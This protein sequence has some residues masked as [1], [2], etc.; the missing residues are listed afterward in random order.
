MRFETILAHLGIALLV[1]T[2]L[3]KMTDLDHYI[4]TPFSFDG[5]KPLLT[6]KPWSLYVTHSDRFLRLDSLPR[7]DA[8]QD[9]SSV[10]VNSIFIIPLTESKLVHAVVVL[11]SGVRVYLRLLN[12]SDELARHVPYSPTDLIL[13]TTI[14]EIVFIRPPPPAAAIHH[15]RHDT[16]SGQPNITSPNPAF[17]N[18]STVTMSGNYLPCSM[19]IPEDHM[20]ISTAYYSHG[21]LILAKEKELTGGFSQADELIGIGQDLIT[22]E[23]PV[24]GT[25]TLKF[26]LC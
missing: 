19:V 17:N 6:I 11:Q 7:L 24:L 3:G 18:P 5:L 12:Y 1:I 22:R 2:S 10:I 13:H 16:P 8:F 15:S 21:V 20:Q 4:C 14:L 25:V 23:V 26:F 9:P